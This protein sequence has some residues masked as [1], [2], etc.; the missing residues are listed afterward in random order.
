LAPLRGR[1]RLRHLVRRRIK[2]RSRDKKGTVV[3]T[4]IRLALTSLA[5]CCITLAAAGTPLPF[6]EAAHK[7]AASLSAPLP[8]ASP[9]GLP[10][11]MSHVSSFTPLR[12]Q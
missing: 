6:L 3:K 4:S 1:N 8:P 2:D 10:P 12:L 11:D 5:V 7:A 9:D